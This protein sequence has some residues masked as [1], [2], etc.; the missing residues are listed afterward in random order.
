VL[1]TTTPQNIILDN[2]SPI[3]RANLF[4][5]AQ[6]YS[7]FWLDINNLQSVRLGAYLGLIITLI[8][9][10]IKN[11]II[12]NLIIKR[13][14]NVQALINAIIAKKNNIPA[15]ALSSLSFNTLTS[16]SFIFSQKWKCFF[17]FFM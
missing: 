4:W 14:H 1:F 8:V 15:H 11:V 16:Y 2:I 9:K 13:F 7:G 6:T 3:D 17:M 12:N 5:G 10:S